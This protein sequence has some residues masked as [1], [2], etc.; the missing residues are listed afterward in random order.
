MVT[1]AFSLP[2]DGALPIGTLKRSTLGSGSAA[3]GMTASALPPPSCMYL[4]RKNPSVSETSIPMMAVPLLMDMDLRKWR[5]DG[6][7]RCSF[8]QNLFA[9]A[10]TERGGRSRRFP[11]SCETCS[12]T[13]DSIEVEGKVER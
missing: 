10:Q 12:A 9:S 13:P 11:S 3:A 1:L 4:P 7:R 8:K 5:A 2:F 6:A